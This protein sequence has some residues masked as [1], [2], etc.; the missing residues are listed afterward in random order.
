MRDKEREIER[1]RERDSQRYF[2]IIYVTPSPVKTSL[3]LLDHILTVLHG[4]VLDLSLK[5]AVRNER[6][7]RGKVKGPRSKP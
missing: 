3:F 6:L 4:D 5:M 2:L 7:E 1:E